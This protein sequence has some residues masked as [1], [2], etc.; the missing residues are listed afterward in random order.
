MGKPVRDTEGR[1][2]SFKR[3]F[4]S[5]VRGVFWVSLL[6]FSLYVSF[7]IGSNKPAI[8]KE[9]MAEE[10]FSDYPL[11]VKICKAES[12]N[13]QFLENG[14]VLRG[15]INHS[16]IGYCQINE[17]IWNDKARELGYDIY[18]EQGN[19]DMAV[20][21]FLNEGSTPWNSSKAAWSQ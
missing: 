5:F 18:T 10:K 14:R 1:F 16:D 6:G 20:H 15:K 3:K 2:T 19:K 11:L 9:V 21:I 8:I 17:P 7:Q 4:K 13:K 12:H